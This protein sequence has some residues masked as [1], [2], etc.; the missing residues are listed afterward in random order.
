MKINLFILLL[1]VSCSEK[2]DGIENKS[3]DFT[4]NNLKE[5][6]IRLIDGDELANIIND[7]KRIDLK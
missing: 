7:F 6:R 4:N 2:K 1:F 5:N 3:W